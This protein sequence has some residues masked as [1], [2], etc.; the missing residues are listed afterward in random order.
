MS[1]EE[2]KDRAKKTGCADFE[3]APGSFKGMSELWNMC[4]ADKTGSTDWSAFMEGM[5]K[6]CFSPESD[7]T[8]KE[9][10]KS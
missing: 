5:K 3:C 1:T 10:K 8:E 9:T 4:C 2:T 7:K 6:A